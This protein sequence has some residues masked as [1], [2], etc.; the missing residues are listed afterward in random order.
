MYN[1]SVASPDHVRRYC[2]ELTRRGGWEVWLEEDKTTRW[3]E[4]YED[5]HRVERAVAKMRREVEGLLDS[6]WTLQ[7]VTR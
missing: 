4:N 7:S 6:G 5:W 1:I 3:S 2:M